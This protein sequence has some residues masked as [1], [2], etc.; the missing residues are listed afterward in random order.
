MAVSSASRRRCRIRS[1]DSSAS[2]LQ[3]LPWKSRAQPRLPTFSSSPSHPWHLL[4]LVLGMGEQPGP[5]GGVGSVGLD[6][7]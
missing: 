5:T 3:I 6:L 2:P 1:H 7:G 4:L